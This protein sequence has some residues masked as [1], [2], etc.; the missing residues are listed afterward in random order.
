[1]PQVQVIASSPSLTATTD[2]RRRSRVRRPCLPPLIRQPRRGSGGG[3]GGILGGIFGAVIRGGMIGGDG[4]HCEP[5][6]AGHPIGADASGR[7]GVTAPSAVATRS[8]RFPEP[9]GSFG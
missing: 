7:T 8:K 4:D 5:P 6:R 2:A 9:A 3:S 1:M